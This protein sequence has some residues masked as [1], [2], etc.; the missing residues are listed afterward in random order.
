[1]SDFVISRLV[2]QIQEWLE[3]DDLN[4]NFYY[5]RSL[6]DLKVKLLLKIKS[7]LILAGADY[8]VAVFAA[9]GEDIRHFDFIRHWDG[10]SF[11]ASE[12]IEFPDPVPFNV[13]VTAERLA[14]N[15]LQHASS[16]ATWT[17]QHVKIAAQKN[18]KLLDTRKT[19]PGLRALEKYAVRVGGG[20]NHRLGQADT[21]M[22]KDNHKT[23][24]GGLSEAWSFF[25]NLGSFYGNIVV[26]VHSIPELQEA[27]GLGVKHVMLDNFSIE[28]ILS[29]IKFKKS[30]M[31]FEVSGGIKFDN[32]SDY[33]INGVDAISLGSL[34]YSAPR[35]D[36]SLK[37]KPV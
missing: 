11:E 26:E 37:F 25:N 35:V 23:C 33:L 28:D 15:L 29:A 12:N 16:I 4:R 20:F 22:I 8:F 14:L 19:T 1:M 10:K 24:L 27:I 3:E 13:A 2:P 6:S 9:L 18:I 36:L 5:T 32:L 7:P 17:H 34:I 30:G 31:T 21:W